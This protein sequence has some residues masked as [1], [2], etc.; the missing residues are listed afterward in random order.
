M[1]GDD[2]RLERVKAARS[3]KL[4]RPPERLQSPPDLELVPKRAVLV[5]QENRLAGSV[6]ARR[7]ARGIQL[8]Q[9]EQSMGFGLDRRDR[10][11]HAADAKRFMA[12]LGTQP[13]RA[14]G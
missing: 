4:A 3:A 12:E 8:H 11:E 5:E 10:G 13:I 9:R 2:C 1:A 14:A 7:D 6:D